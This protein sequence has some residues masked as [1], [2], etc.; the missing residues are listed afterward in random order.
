MRHALVLVPI[1]LVVSLLP[2]SGSDPK[3]SG[4]VG[5]GKENPQPVPSW[6]QPLP[7]FDLRQIRFSLASSFDPKVSVRQSEPGATVVVWGTASQ[8]R[9]EEMEQ[10]AH[11]FAPLFRSAFDAGTSA[12]VGRQFLSRV[13]ELSQ[14][15]NQNPA[16]ASAPSVWYN[17]QDPWARDPRSWKK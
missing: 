10:F 7:R 15:P 14:S 1:L 8:A 2:A 12:T 13:V 4:W 9:Q 3:V 11:D 16:P 6:I 5:I 17:A